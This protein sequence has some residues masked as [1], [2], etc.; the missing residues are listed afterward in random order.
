MDG[1]DLSS[2]LQCGRLFTLQWGEVVEA[3][4]D[5]VLVD[6]TAPNGSE[7]FIA[8]NLFL[9][10]KG[11]GIEKNPNPARL[12]NRSYQSAREQAISEPD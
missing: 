10:F 6:D 5:T 7:G 12:V 11:A 4:D 1:N 9:K 2:T 8:E 3:V